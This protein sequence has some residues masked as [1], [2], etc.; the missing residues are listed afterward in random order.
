M[1]INCNKE[2]RTVSVWIN[3]FE[4]N[5][6]AVKAELELLYTLYRNT[7]YL[8]VVFESGDGNLY[9]SMLGLLLY[10]RERSI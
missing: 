6:E 2:A 7:K 8:I 4:K 3:K 9:E 10:N 1:E 5:N